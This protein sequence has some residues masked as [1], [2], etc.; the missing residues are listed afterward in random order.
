MDIYTLLSDI[1]HRAHHYLTFLQRYRE[2]SPPRSATDSEHTELSTALDC[3]SALST[4]ISYDQNLSE[5]TT[6]VA[7]VRRLDTLLSPTRTYLGT[8]NVKLQGRT[9]AEDQK[10]LV[11]FGTE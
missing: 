2:L 11:L 1:K 7:R 8:A 5:L 9:G 3:L 6:L 4:Q 10:T